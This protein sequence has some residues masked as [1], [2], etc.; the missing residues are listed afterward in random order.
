MLKLTG[1]QLD[2]FCTGNEGEDDICWETLLEMCFDAERVGRIDENTSVLRS[3]D[4]FDDR[5]KIIDI[6]ESFHAK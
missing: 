5:C 1:T 4:G 2:E 3:N 6:G